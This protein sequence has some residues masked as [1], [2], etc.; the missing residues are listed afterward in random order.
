MAMQDCLNIIKQAAGEGKITDQQAEQLLSEIDDFITHKKKLLEP[1]NLDATIAQHLQ[2]RLKDSILQAAIEKRNALI[3]AKVIANVYN[4]VSAFENAAEGLS[5][6]LVGSIKSKV[7][8]KLSIDAEGKAL[9]SKYLGRLIND[10]EK[11]GWLEHFSKGHMDDDIARELWEIRPNGTPGKTNNPIAQGIAETIHKYQMVAVERLN[12]AGAYINPRPGY[13]F[14]QSHDQ[15]LLRQAGFDEWRNFILDKLDFEETFKGADPEEFL[16][17]AYRGLSTGLHKKFKGEGESNYLQGFTGPANLAKRASQ[18]RI[19][20]FKDADSFMA[21]NDKFGTRDLREGVISGLEHMARNTALMEGLGT[22]PVA[23]FDKILLEL[24]TKYRDDPVMFDKLSSKSLINQLK[25]IDGTTRIPGS[26]SL[27][28][29]GSINR[30][31]QNM[32]KL[33]GA[34]ISSI[35]DLPSQ[36]AELRYQGVPLFKAYSDTFLNLFQ[37][38]GNA[39]QKELARLIGVG[40]EG[41]LGDVHARFS[42][43]DSVPGRM[44]KMQ[45][46][47]FKLNGMSWW[48]D[49]NRTG[50]GLIMS[51]HLAE[52]AGKSFGQLDEKLRNVLQQYQ[53]GEG[54][55]NLYTK[56]GVHDGGNGNKYMTSDGLEDIPDAEIAAYLKA[57]TGKKPT[58]RAIKEGRDELISRL[59][60]YYQDRS[61]HAVPQ[62]GAAERAMLNQGTSVG[63]LEGEAL[64][65]I[66][67]FKSFPVTMLRRGLGREIY[68]TGDGKTDI[69]GLVH[70]MA[71][72]TVFGYMS[73]VAKDILKGRE[74]RTFNDD[75][76]NN[77]KLMSA[78]M[79]QGGGLGIYG[80]FLF[81]EYSRYGRSFLSTLAGPTFGQVDDLAEILTRIRTGEDVGANVM[82]TVIN[83]TPFINLFYTRQ[84]LDYLFLYELQEMVNPGYLRRMESRIMRENDQRFFVPPSQ[85]VPYGGS[86][87]SLVQ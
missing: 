8:S 15:T 72:T 75:P 26:V 16:R 82:R 22:N 4:R 7:G 29:I 43:Q 24:K 6:L 12:R 83:N 70:L 39:E 81:G 61:D 86:L 64:R 78:A 13:L 69:M 47:F 9:A 84:A 65:T 10:L 48:N 60:T 17:G 87:R 30:A 23:N 40:F 20:H 63:T 37:G 36:A 71:A 44:A 67:Q 73:M 53:I 19:L 62:P 51:N 76:A 77:I 52:N 33:G 32:A 41:L 54:E 49:T 42:S 50:T 74:P 1:E 18:E 34:V 57:Q 3:N 66:M 27:A 85:H 35:T 31:I 80:D 5:A 25:E 59:D 11:G 55:W 46:R 38:R 28:K 68:G 2:S 14:R 45:Q 58:A 79:S 21:Y 56:H